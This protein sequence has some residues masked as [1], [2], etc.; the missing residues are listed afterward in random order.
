[1]PRE[2]ILDQLESNKDNCKQFWKVIREVIPSDKKV[3][4][5]DILLKEKGVKMDR[6]EVAGYINNYFINV[7]NFSKPEGFDCPLDNAGTTAAEPSLT[8]NIANET[9]ENLPHMKF[10]ELK[11]VNVYRIVKEINVSKSSGLDNVSSFIV[12]EAFQSLIPEIT[13]M[14]NLSLATSVFPKKWKEALVVPI[15]KSGDSTLVKNYRPISLLPLPGKIFEKLVHAQITYHLEGNFLLTDTQHGFRRGHSTLHSVE[16]FTSYINVKMDN[17]LPTLAT[18]IDFRKA[19][20]CVQ[21]PM[22]LEK[23]LHLHLDKSVVSWVK[24]YL[25]SR[26]QRVLAN[27]SYSSFETIKQGVP[28]GSVLGPLFYIIYANDLLDKIIHCKVALYADDTVLFM[29]NKNFETSIK[30]MQSD[31]NSIEAWCKTN[32]I[33]ANTDKTKIMLFGSKHTLKE[34]PPHIIHFGSTNLQS[35]NTYKYLGVTLDSQL[36]YALHVN[37]IISSIS[38]KLKQFQRMR[39]FLNARA[40]MLVYK[41]MLLP[42]LEYGDIFMSAATL[43]NRKKLQ[44]LQNKGLRCALNRGI[45]TSTNE[46]HADANLLKLKHRRRQHLLNFMFDKTQNSSCLKIRDKNVAITRSQRKKTMKVKKPRTEKFKKCLAY[47]G[48]TIWNALPV[49]LHVADDKYTYKSLVA[50][51]IVQ[52]ACAQ[53]N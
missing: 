4:K 48:P 44:V 20:D 21:H 36:N 47:R 22:L 51:L 28:Q 41:S 30:Q 11:E 14:F 2:F 25:A 34:V 6:G 23:L 10:D 43:K 17:K 50:K 49:D 9:Q 19:F 31:I 13:H 12:K 33:M 38:C 53:E 24:S 45:E 15:P 37:K 32:G 40:A 16:Q 42:I 29:A 26:S 27:G 8:G 3:D 52:R 35:V 1:M 46:L 39:N 5:Q 7:G 18:F